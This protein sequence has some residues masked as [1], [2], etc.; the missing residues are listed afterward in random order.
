M[1]LEREAE[2]GL[3]VELLRG[4]GDSGG[5]VVLIRGEAG[6]GKSALVRFFVDSSADSARVHVGFCDDL[7]TPQP[8]GPFWDVA[9][10]E[11]QLQQALRESDR[12][13]VLETLVDLLTAPLRPTVVVIEDT[14]WSDEATLDAIKYVG[15]RIGRANGLLIL[16]YRVGEVDLDHPL[17]TVIG[18]LPPQSVIRIELGGLSRSAV[19][20][21]IQGSGLDADRVFELTHG[22][23]LLVTE[24]ASTGSDD[25]PGS[26]RDSV[27]ARVGKLSPP[28][29][30]M[31]R[32]ISVIP[33]RIPRTEF[34]SVMGGSADQLAEFDRLDLLEVGGDTLSFK[35]E[36]IRRAVEASLTISESVAIHRTLL[37]KL[38]A[39]TSPARLV[40]HARFAKDVQRLIEY[41]PA[42]ARAASEVGSHREASAHYRGLEPYLD[43]LGTLD[44]AA[45]LFDWARVEYFVGN[46]RS[47]EILDRAIGVYREVGSEIGLSRSLVLGVEL[48]RMHGRFDSAKANALEAIQILERREPSALLARA[49]AAEAWLLIHRGLIRQAEASADKA[50]RIA[51]ATGAESA[52]LEALGVKGTLLYVRGQAGGLDFMDELRQRAN[53]GGYA[54]QEVWALLRM[55]TVA[56]EIRDLERASYFSVQARETAVRF[57]LTIL[58]TLAI[59]V[60]AEARFWGGQWAEAEDL[61]TE[62]LGRHSNADAHLAAVLG[63]LRTRTG[64]GAGEELLERAWALARKSNEIDHLLISA[65]ARAE[66]MWIDN[67]PD[68]ELLIQFQDLVERGI[69]FEYPW[70]AAS[71]AQWLWMLGDRETLDGLPQ[72]YR[73][74]FEG[75]IDAAA[76]FWE[77]RQIPYERAL[78]LMCGDM[79]QRLQA[80]HLLETLGASAVAS[81]VRREL[82]AAGVSAPR[83]RGKATR[84]HR[85]G[86][87]GRQ[88]EVLILLDEGLTNAQIADRLFVSPRTVE[89]HVSALL[90]KLNSSTRSEAVARARREG[91]FT[92]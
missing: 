37:E 70:P 28:A 30:E 59:S 72:P 6:I 66:K 68:T 63:V 51:E 80:L 55:A 82:R 46:K 43:H 76:Q 4:V 5:K 20:E 50:I 64:R 16:T 25:V 52:M 8:F 41:A 61:A 73:D 26:V 71:L 11:P 49:L 75:R 54:H 2:L 38:P 32:V 47:I 35:H 13:A 23:P 90:A 15:R 62:A 53:R 21:I 67:R 56:L 74:L 45:I 27:L 29:R 24:M 9:R 3:L 86:L 39:S 12:Q 33:E 92:R 60:Y 79:A 81:K 7:Q 36:L 77:S 22:N 40:H 85:A 31:L 48:N 91:L 19:A 65:A 10:S 1:I 17:R 69:R 88:A 58:E 57:E 89:N 34:F 84:S 87:T 44:R 78:A 42:A 14:Q 83:G 18:D